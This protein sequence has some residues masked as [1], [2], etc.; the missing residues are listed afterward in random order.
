MDGGTN[1]K[2]VK[3]W[4][5]ERLPVEGAG[6]AG[7]AGS[8]SGY[9]HVEN[10]VFGGEQGEKVGVGG[11]TG[12]EVTRQTRQTRHVSAPTPAPAV[13]APCP[14]DCGSSPRTKAT[15]RNGRM[16]IWAC[17]SG[18]RPKRALTAQKWGLTRED[19]GLVCQ[20]CHPLRLTK[21]PYAIRV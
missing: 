19:R 1:R 20:V 15:F 3:L 2:G 18:P 14:G 10:M 4:K 16:S 6:S 21:N 12:A 11:S 5:V 8:D 9:L 17:A 7:S 13:P